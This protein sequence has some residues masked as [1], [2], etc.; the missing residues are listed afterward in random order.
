MPVPQPAKRIIRSA[1]SRRL[2]RRAARRS[3]RI[4]R[5]TNSAS[6]RAL[7]RSRFCELILGVGR[8]ALKLPLHRI[9]LADI[10]CNEMIAAALVRVHLKLAARESRGGT[11]AAEMDE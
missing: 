3:F 10:A 9:D 6:D 1:A 8:Q 11:R 2:A 7:N 5:E 4:A